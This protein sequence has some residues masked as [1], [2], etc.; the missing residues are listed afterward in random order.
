[1]YGVDLS[2]YQHGIN[3]VSLP[4][5]FV[6]IKATEGLTMKDKSFDSFV[7]QLTRTNKLIGCYHY[8]RPDNRKNSNEMKKEARFFINT[9][10]ETGLLGKAIL[11]CDWEQK[12]TD[13]YNYLEAW[14][15]EVYATTGIIPFIYASREV[16]YKAIQYGI[17]TPYKCWLAQ[18]PNSNLYTAGLGPNLTPPSPLMQ[19]SDKLVQWSIWQYTSN[20]K[21]NGYNG[22]VDL[23][24]CPF[25]RTEWLKWGSAV[26]TNIT[27]SIPEE[28]QWAIDNGLFKGY[29]DGTFRPYDPVTRVQLATVLQRFYN[30]M[31][32]K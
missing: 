8:A 10:K 15:E 14:L 24:Y 7:S 31:E 4:V 18:W 3:I 9:I 27:E 13:R 19:S 5:D 11:I 16:L 20:G 28:M 17:R 12:P 30:M 21:V 29:G 23:D 32:D 6:I 25:D 22:R 26:D 1:M 2:N